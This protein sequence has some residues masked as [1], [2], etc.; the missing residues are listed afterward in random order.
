MAVTLGRNVVG[1]NAAFV[2][3]DAGPVSGQHPANANRDGKCAHTIKGTND[4]GIKI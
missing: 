1:T 3:P 4:N 2:G